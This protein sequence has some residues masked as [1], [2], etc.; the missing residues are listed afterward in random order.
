MKLRFWTAI[1]GAII[2]M[3]A[4]TQA[5]AVL[6]L[7]LANDFDSSLSA[8]VV[9]YHDASNAWVTKGWYTV[10][11]KNTQTHN[12][13]TSQREIY[14]YAELASGRTWGNGDVTRYVINEAFEYRDGQKCPP[15][16]KRI[17]AGFTKYTAKDNVVTYRPSGARGPLPSG[18]GRQ[19]RRDTRSQLEKNAAHL[20]SFVNSSR[21]EK[22]LKELTTNDALYQAAL[23]RA[24]EMAQKYDVATRP[25]GRRYDTALTDHGVSFSKSWTSAVT[26]TSENTLAIYQEFSANENFRKQILTAEFTGLGV[27]IFESRG[28][29]YTV[30]LFTVAGSPQTEKGLG[31]SLKDLEKSFRE[32]RD[33]FR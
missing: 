23:T 18:G 21:K 24:R 12:L 1:L 5:F 8:A 7:R 27:G 10:G 11:G 29:Y 17:N 16:T 19:E 28:K 26:T 20:V 6:E 25:D 15:G 3:Y 4:P 14:I 30:M 33:I 22:G 2:V 32:L 13:P 9:Y 31:E